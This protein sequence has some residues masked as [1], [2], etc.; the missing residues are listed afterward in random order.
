MRA[1]YRKGASRHLALALRTLE[2]DS[3]SNDQNKGERGNPARIAPF[4]C[5]RRC[6]IFIELT[7]A[8]LARVV[9]EAISK[10]A[11]NCYCSCSEY[12]YT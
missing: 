3:Q 1:V 12:V 9:H 8:V 7:I 2:A 4:Y 5:S 6:T 11:V 10:V